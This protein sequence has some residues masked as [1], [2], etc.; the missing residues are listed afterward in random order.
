MVKLL[1]SGYRD[2][3]P[4]TEGSASACECIADV[5]GDGP[6]LTLGLHNDLTAVGSAV[7]RAE[8]RVRQ[9]LRRRPCFNCRLETAGVESRQIVVA[10]SL[11]VMSKLRV[12]LD[13]RDT[14]FIFRAFGFLSAILRV[15]DQRTEA[16][17]A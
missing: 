14:L 13:H 4:R 10:R 7:D 2:R 15:D 17:N 3:R 11:D 12:H 9:R 1:G 8:L 5:K 6:G 16:I